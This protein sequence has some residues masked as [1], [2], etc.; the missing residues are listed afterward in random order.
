MKGFMAE[1]PDAKVALDQLAYAR[2][3]SATYNTVGVRKALA[4]GVQAV[5]SGKGPRGGDGG[6]AAAGRFAHEIVCGTNRIENATIGVPV[7]RSA[8][9]C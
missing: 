7:L 3:W 4:D 9:P 8:A 5:L 2:D 6:G 1:H